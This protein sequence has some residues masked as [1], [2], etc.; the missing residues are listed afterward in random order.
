MVKV[1]GILA[2]CLAF[3]AQAE[4]IAS[5]SGE[6]ITVGIYTDKCALNSVSNLPYKATWTEKGKVSQGCYGINS[7]V[8]VFYWEDKTVVIL[9]VSL[10]QRTTGI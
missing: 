6:G 3:S 4:Q 7:G 9:P 1:L 8:A 10:F 5:A 2:L